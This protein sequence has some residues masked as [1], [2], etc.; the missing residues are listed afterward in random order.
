VARNPS[1]ASARCC[2]SIQPG[3]WRPGLGFRQF[4]YGLKWHTSKDEALKAT[5][6]QVLV[7][8]SYECESRG[9][10]RRVMRYASFSSYYEYWDCISRYRSGGRP[11]NLHEV[12]LSTKP[13][14]LY[15]DLDGDSRFRSIHNEIIEWLRQYVRWF[16]SADRIG[17]N[18]S[19]P[20]PVVLVS[21]DPSKYSCHVLFPE[22][23]F[24]DH[25]TQQ[26]YLPALLTALPALE[27]DI[28][29]HE[30]LPILQVV[31]DRVP[32]SKFQSL[33]GPYACKLKDG[34]LRTDTQLVPEDG[35]FQGDPLT[36][37]AGYVDTSY[38]LPMPP[39]SQLLAWNS[40]ISDLHEQHRVR[41]AAPDGG[42]AVSPQD[43][44]NL[45]DTAFQRYQGGVL[46]L[47]GKT[48]IAV[49]EEALKWIHPE[50]ALQYWSWFRICGVTCKMLEQYANDTAAQERIW[51]AHKLWSGSY[52]QYSDEENAQKVEEARG[53]RISGLALL[54]RLV[55]FDNPNM[56]IRMRIWPDKGRDPQPLD[57][58]GIIVGELPLAW[59]DVTLLSWFSKFGDVVDAKVFKDPMTGTSRGFGIVRF[60]AP[61]SADHAIQHG[62]GSI[63]DGSSLTVR[64]S[65]QR[66]WGDKF[67][68]V[69]PGPGHH[70]QIKAPTEEPVLTTAVA[71]QSQ[72]PSQSADLILPSSSLNLID[73]SDRIVQPPFQRGRAGHQPR[74]ADPQPLDPSGVIVGRLPPAWIDVTLLT[75]FSKFGDVVDAKVFKDPTTGT[76]R[77]FGIVRFQAPESADLAIQHG[78]GSVV[79]GSSLTV[80]QSWQRRW[81][82]KFQDLG[83]GSG[84]RAQSMAPTEQP[85]L[86]AAAAGQPQEW[87]RDVLH[88]TG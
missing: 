26:G 8:S 24:A 25:A 84:H 20:K 51:L 54:R 30:T 10:V 49:Y 13:R 16:F 53:K 40:E 41:V 11:Q 83:P 79:D 86:T 66:R 58:S 44:A 18:L 82:D 76:S 80:K 65:W 19:S 68:L 55:C 34:E 63:V 48:D 60:Q 27:V 52:P 69:G 81:G 39:L 7:S 37:F 31:V 36:C 29:D 9:S 73:G 14:C 50:R 2:A 56:Q 59:I 6:G 70:F 85:A 61:E 35:F 46:D 12:L 28:D 1:R 3:P 23:Q 15:F 22:L 38:A 57:P 43:I 75:W 17:W 45:Y 74:R 67:E 5:P 71:E 21:S 72:E 78:N 32:Y 42:N 64:R 77:R 4:E 87:R 47:A 88:R 62:N 33:R